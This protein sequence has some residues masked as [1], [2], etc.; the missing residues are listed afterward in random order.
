MLS[1]ERYLVLISL[2]IFAI[3]HLVIIL[4]TCTN[5]GDML[6]LK[7]EKLMD[8]LEKWKFKRGMISLLSL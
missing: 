3:N 1:R 5:E 2:E 8:L 7:N 6:T 4:N